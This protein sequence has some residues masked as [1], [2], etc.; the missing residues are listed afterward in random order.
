MR[1]VTSLF[2]SRDLLTG[3]QEYN[4]VFVAKPPPKTTT[5]NLFEKMT[6]DAK[7]KSEVNR[8]EVPAPLIR[9]S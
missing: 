7:E 3:K 4:R 9:E 5:E 1:D 8:R 6:L 2:E